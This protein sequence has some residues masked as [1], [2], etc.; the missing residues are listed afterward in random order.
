[1]ANAY[2]KSSI[3]S[4]IH[5]WWWLPL[6][7]C[8][9]QTIAVCDDTFLQHF[10]YIN[11]AFSTSNFANYSFLFYIVVVCKPGARYRHSASVIFQNVPAHSIPPPPLYGSAVVSFPPFCSSRC[12]KVKISSDVECV[13]APNRQ[14]APCACVRECLGAPVVTPD[15]LCFYM[16]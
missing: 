2:P 8:G 3:T 5:L 9:I 7:Q 11:G 13:C 12:E 6:R 14:G 1:M 15:A 4:Y 16:R 10:H